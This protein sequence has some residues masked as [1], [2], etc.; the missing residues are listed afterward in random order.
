MNRLLIVLA[1]LLPTTAIAQGLSLD[2]PE[3][4]ATNTVELRVGYDQAFVAQ[5]GYARATSLFGHA[6]V[7]DADVT[8]PW[9][10]LDAE[11][12]RVRVGAAV[13]LLGSG[14]WNLRARLAPTLRATDNVIARFLGVGADLSVL[15]GYR[16][17][18]WFIGA[19]AGLDAE[20]ATYI[21]PS[22]EYR[23]RVY[24]DA[25]EGWYSGSGGTLRYGLQVGATIGG[26]EISLRA[27]QMYTTARTPTLLPFFATLGY[28]HHW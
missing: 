19:E 1:L 20:L 26:G 14:R 16:G 23:T 8:L 4:A 6:V 27:G 17:A 5:L 24:D 2:A 7:L 10:T 12:G 3:R 15:G 28:S 21:M 9:D 11:D 22:D 18:R 25:H 13:S